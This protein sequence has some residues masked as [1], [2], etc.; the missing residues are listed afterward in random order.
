MNLLS[1]IPPSERQREGSTWQGDA[2]PSYPEASVE[3]ASL[4][5]AL[6]AWLG[7]MTGY[8]SPA[9]LAG[10]W[11]DWASHLLL[12]PVKQ[13]ELCVQAAANVQRWLQYSAGACLGTPANPVAPLAQDKRFTDP[14]WQA[15]P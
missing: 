15:W 10:A 13:T 1:E 9:A 8:I 6:G 5:L 3:H 14:L 11:Q 2:H 4:D 7:R 12:S